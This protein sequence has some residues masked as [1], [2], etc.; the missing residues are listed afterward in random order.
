MLELLLLN[1][2]DD[3]DFWTIWKGI[4]SKTLPEFELESNITLRSTNLVCPWLHDVLTLIKPYNLRP[5]TKAQLIMHPPQE[6]LF[7]NNNEHCNDYINHHIIRC[8]VA[9]TPKE[10]EKKTKC[11][12]TLHSTRTH[13]NKTESITKQDTTAWQWSTA[14]GSD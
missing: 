6:V 13:E 8:S 1:L 12:C 11:Q 2:R 9:H 10:E 5:D 4:V 7:L 14:L 3:F